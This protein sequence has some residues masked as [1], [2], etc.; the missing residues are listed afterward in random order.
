S[1]D[2]EEYI[3]KAKAC[4]LPLRYNTGASGQLVLLRYMRNKKMIIARRVDVIQEYLEDG[5]SG[6]FIESIEEE[7]PRV[8]K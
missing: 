2:F 8:I 4:I 1:D 5:V 7:L 6:I 3:R